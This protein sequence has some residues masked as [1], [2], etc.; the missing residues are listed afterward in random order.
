MQIEK[1]LSNIVINIALLYFSDRKEDSATIFAKQKNSEEFYFCP[2]FS[3]I[4][5]KSTLAVAPIS[6]KVGLTFGIAARTSQLSLFKNC[7]N[8]SCILSLLTSIRWTLYLI[9]SFINQI[10]RIIIFKTFFWGKNK[11]EYNIV[12]RCYTFFLQE[13]KPKAQLNFHVNK[14]LRRRLYVRV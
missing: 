11:I 1:I 4:S 10:L 3:T 2:V 8:L 7:S 12:N 6:W 14:F 5:R 9:F 13:K